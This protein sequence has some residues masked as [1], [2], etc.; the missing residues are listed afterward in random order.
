MGFV[1]PGSLHCIRPEV[2]VLCILLGFSSR[3][4]VGHHADGSHHVI[5]FKHYGTII[6]L[7]L[8]LVMFIHRDVPFLLHIMDELCLVPF[9]F[10]Q[11]DES[12]EYSPVVSA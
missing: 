11:Q 3:D 5:D 10:G 6:I 1:V 12:C 9:S 7:I 2:I 8:A 4:R